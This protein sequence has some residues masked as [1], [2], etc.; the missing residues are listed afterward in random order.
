MRRRAFEVLIR[1][2]GQAWASGSAS[3]AAACFAELVDYADPLRYRFSS[4][5]ELEPFFGPGPRG[6]SIVWH[7][8]LFDELAQTGVVEYTYVGHHRYHGAAIVE[9]DGG[10][11]I[12]AWREW[13]HRDDER[14]WE[15]YLAGP[16]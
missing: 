12:S 2:L 14:D 4:R 11:L 10:G 5:A 9:I 7:R 3:D 1:R 8:I 6:H 13:Q 16:S 15:A